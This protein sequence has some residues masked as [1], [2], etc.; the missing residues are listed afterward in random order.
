LIDTRTGYVYSAY[1]VT[2]KAE[3]FSTSWGSKDTA[4][5][6]R[7]DNEKEAFKKLIDE[8][9]ASWPKLLERHGQKE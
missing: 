8:M 4:D 6:A 2:Q 5:K 3:T 7:S 9:I 1:E